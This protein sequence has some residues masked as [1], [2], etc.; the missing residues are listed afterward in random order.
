MAILSSAICIAIAIYLDDGTFDLS[1]QIWNIVYWF[2]AGIYNLRM[3]VSSVPNASLINAGVTWTLFW[4]W[5]FYFSLP[6]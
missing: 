5:A 2:D 6:F 3:N 4:E 1:K